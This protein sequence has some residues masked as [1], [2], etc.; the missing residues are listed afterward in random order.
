MF[1]LLLVRMKH[2]IFYY[3]IPRFTEETV[4]QELCHQQV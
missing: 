4:F 1:I 3:Y 2:Y